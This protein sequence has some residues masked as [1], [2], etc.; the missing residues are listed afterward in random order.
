MNS[1]E[2]FTVID[3][4]IYNQSV[5]DSELIELERLE[6]FHW[7]YMIRKYIIKDW[8][9]KLPKNSRI[10]DLGSATGG[11]SIVLREL[12]FK[13]TGIELSDFGYQTQMA[14]GLDVIQADACKIPFSDNTFDVVICLDLLEHIEHDSV[15]ISEVVRVVKEDGKILISVPEDMAMWSEHDIAVSHYRRY[16]LEDISNLCEFAGIKLES[17]W[18][19]NILLKPIV[20]LQ[21]L[22]ASGSALK[23]IN[24]IMNFGLFVFA[25]I[26]YR[27]FRKLAS[28]MTIWISGN[29]EK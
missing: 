9:T 13:V 2:C 23:E 1:L 17:V 24:P 12:G 15:A 27:L 11:N 20:K 19:S 22:R 6:N 26:E 16:S 18:R 8:S 25:V 3:P 7:W 5:K 21:R 10:L 4:T 14:K 29:V 28:G